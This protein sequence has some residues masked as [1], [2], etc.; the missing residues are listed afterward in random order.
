MYEGDNV[1]EEVDVDD[2]ACE[3]A[4]L[5]RLFG[6]KKKGD[7]EFGLLLAWSELNLAFGVI[8]LLL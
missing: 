2:D 3:I 1:D 8:K 4:P 6:V 5:I 7:S